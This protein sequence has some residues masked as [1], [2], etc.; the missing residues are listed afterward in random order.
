MQ[1][2]TEAD[3]VLPSL[4]LTTKKV[5]K[6]VDLSNFQVIANV[7]AEIISQLDFPAKELS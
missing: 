5:A 1:K 4:L 7:A 2:G 3:E 6:T